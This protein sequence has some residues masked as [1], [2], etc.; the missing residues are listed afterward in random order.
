MNEKLEMS[1]NEVEHKFPVLLR[2]TEARANERHAWMSEEDAH[3]GA[4]QGSGWAGLGLAHPIRSRGIESVL[5][6]LIVQLYFL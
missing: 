2:E 6:I 5:M 1:T 4:T 3:L